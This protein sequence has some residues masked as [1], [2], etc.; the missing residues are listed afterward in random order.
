MMQATRQVWLKSRP[1][2]ASR[3]LKILILVDSNVPS[4]CVSGEFFVQNH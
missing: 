2:Q 4:N 1:E 3:K